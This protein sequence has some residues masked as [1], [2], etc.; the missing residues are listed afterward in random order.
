MSDSTNLNTGEGYRIRPFYVTID[1]SGSMGPVE[2]GSPPWPIDVV[3]QEFDA[4][5]KILHSEPEVGEVIRLALVS[6]A[7]TAKIECPLSD[8]DQIMSLP[9]LQAG[10]QTSYLK[11]LQK[12][13]ETIDQDSH[14]RKPNL[15]YRP[16]VLFITDGYPNMEP[17]DQWQAERNRLLDTDWSPHPIFVVFGFGQANKEVI[18]ILASGQKYTGVALMALKNETPANQISRIMRD[19]QE[20]IVY[21]AQNSAQFKINKENYLVLTEHEIDEVEPAPIPYG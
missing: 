12:L 10:G 18:K 21:S 3:N 16:V 19:L 11:P 14:H 5:L 2:G 20:S 9:Q 17:E 7:Q 8:P 15:W 13:Y 6:F 4:L 1:V